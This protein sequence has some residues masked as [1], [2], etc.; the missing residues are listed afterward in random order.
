MSTKRLFSSP[1]EALALRAICSKD[2]S[3]SG[4]VLANVDETYFHNEP[5]VE[6]YQAILKHMGKSG[7]PPAFTFLQEDLGLS[8]EA[9][10]FLKLIE[11][12]Q[13]KNLPQAEQLV[14]TLSEYRKTRL[15]FKL[16]KGILRRLQQDQIDVDDLVD[17]VARRVVGITSLKSTENSLYHIGKD[18]NVRDLIEEIIFS[19]DTSHIIPTGFK[20]YD[21]VNGG[22]RRGALTLL[23]GATSSGKSLLMNQLALNQATLGYKVNVVPLEMDTSEL[24]SRSISNISGI[25]ASKIQNKQMAKDEKELAMK[26]WRRRERRIAKAGGRITIF[27]PQS[28]MT[29][30][31][32]TNALHSIKSDI[33]YIDY[34]GLLKGADGEDQWRR[35]GQ[36]AR[37]A[38]IHA[39]LTGKCVVLLCQVDQEGTVR[40]SRAMVE[41]ASTSWIFVATRETREAGFLQVNMN[42]GRNERLISFTIKMDYSTQSAKDMSPE[43]MD[44]VVANTTK[45][46][47][48]KG[49]KGR[50]GRQN[51]V[52]KADDDY[53]PDL[54][55]DSV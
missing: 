41:H 5:A 16:G 2:R 38:K 48:A 52:Q 44:A 30:E 53:L 47:N 3:V 37:Y 36:I 11:R 12:K 51:K 13:I 23:G 35:L 9:C 8:T 27:K 49:R 42:K 32:I 22:F 20:A 26:R 10:E 19:D 7:M 54:T 55:S 34:V 39:E 50:K 43:E 28:D 33:I 14:S 45:N 17:T 4:Y 25:D 1:S 29:I 6:A 15:L 18:S 40:Y 24:L 46:D 31:E 21:G